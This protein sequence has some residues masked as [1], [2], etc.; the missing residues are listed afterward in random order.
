MLLT[1]IFITC[2]G[3]CY[4]LLV[5]ILIATGRGVKAAGFLGL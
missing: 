4:L 5:T 2:L 1:F 3:H